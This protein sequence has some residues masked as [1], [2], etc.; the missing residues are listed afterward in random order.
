MSDDPII[1][2]VYVMAPDF[3]TSTSMSVD[4]DMTQTD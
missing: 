4:V 3:E 2:E 1:A